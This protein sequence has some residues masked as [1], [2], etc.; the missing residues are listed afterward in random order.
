MLAAIV[1]WNAHEYRLKLKRQTPTLRSWSVRGARGPWPARAS[2][3][4][5]AR[6]LPTGMGADSRVRRLPAGMRTITGSSSRGETD[7]HPQELERVQR[8][9]VHEPQGL[10]VVQAHGD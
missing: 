6:R 2:S 8:Q 4:S 3:R 1:S 10:A 5:G 9:Q 7:A